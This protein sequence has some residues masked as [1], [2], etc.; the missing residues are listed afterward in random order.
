MKTITKEID[1]KKEL[2]E[3]LNDPNYKI[4]NINYVIEEEGVEYYRIEV[5]KII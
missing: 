2:L 1:N 5:Q 3:I 4:L